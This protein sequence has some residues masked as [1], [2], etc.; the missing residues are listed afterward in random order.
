MATKEIVGVHSNSSGLVG[1]DATASTSSAQR[2]VSVADSLFIEKDDIPKDMRAMNY[3]DIMILG[4]TGQGKTTTADKLLI[5]N[6]GKIDYKSVYPNEEPRVDHS[7]QQLTIQDLSMWLIPNDQHA[8]DRITTRL[9]NLAFYRVLDNPHKEV[10]QSHAGKMLVNERTRSCELLSN[11]TTRVRVLDIP[12]F[13]CAVR[14]ANQ[15]VS[16]ITSKAMATHLGTMRSILQIQAAMAMKFKRI[17][18]FLPCRDT[19]QILNAALQEELKIMEYYFGRSIFKKMVLVATLGPATYKVVSEKIPLEFP[20]EE[21]EISRSTFHEA[22]KS[23]IPESKADQ[24]LKDDQQRL[25]QPK[26]AG[27]PN[28]SIIFISLR[29]T[30]ESILNK[31]QEA[32]VNGEEGL[33]LQL[34]STV[35]SRCPMTIGERKRE[36]VAVTRKKDWSQAILYENSLCHPLIVP[37]YTTQEK[38]AYKVRGLILGDKHDLHKEKCHNCGKEPGTD[39]C[40]PVGST[41]NVG[42]ESLIVDHTCVVEEYASN[43]LQLLQNI[44]SKHETL[45]KEIPCASPRSRSNSEKVDPD[46]NSIGERD[47]FS[48]T[49]YECSERGKTKAGARRFIDAAGNDSTSEADRREVSMCVE[50]VQVDI[51]PIQDGNVSYMFL[52]TKKT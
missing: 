41:Y 15:Q 29:D 14:D 20:I 49:T 10:N 18:Y 36:R 34:S 6:P 44:P 39:G 16:G 51:E 5:A 38:M 8:L 3:Y 19:L 25:N 48:D 42:E 1:R 13:L 4:T 12:G 21:L 47:V 22:L 11:E 23:L 46:T 2:S 17:L 45:K 27:T 26:P 50:K 43:H 9:K 7:K 30:C 40:L 33:Q 32:E 24:P 37:K 52:Y 28:P 31:V 35:C